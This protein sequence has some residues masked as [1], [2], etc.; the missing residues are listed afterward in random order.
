MVK[1]LHV[2]GISITKRSASTT[3]YGTRNETFTPT[4]WRQIRIKPGKITLRKLHNIFPRYQSK[5]SRSKLSPRNLSDLRVRSRGSP[6]PAQWCWSR[7]HSRQTSRRWTSGRRVCWRAS[8]TSQCTWLGCCSWWRS[9]RKSDYHC[10]WRCSRLRSCTS[11]P[12]SRSWTCPCPC[13]SETER[14]IEWVKTTWPLLTKDWYGSLPTKLPSLN[15]SVQ[16]LAESFYSLAEK[17]RWHWCWN[18][19]PNIKLEQY[20]QRIDTLLAYLVTFTQLFSATFS[21]IVLF[22]SGKKF[23]DIDAE[24]SY[25][26]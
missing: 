21:W 14:P 22:L 23:V 16:H 25:Q 6:P 19:L 18:I 1:H 8:C 7:W 20:L 15:C 13:K 9:C 11:G 2:L 4:L 3:N 24:T 10:R 26:T 17:I 12:T 5:L